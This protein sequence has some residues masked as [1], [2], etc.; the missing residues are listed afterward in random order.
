MAGAN[1]GQIAYWNG[2]IGAVWA[3]EQKKR[4]RE[5]AAITRAGLE[6]AAPHMGE[7]ALDVGCGSG[8]TT[9]LLA[10]R[11]GPKGSATGIDI[12]KPMLDVAAE[13]VKEAGSRATFIEADATDHKFAPRSFDL[14]FSQFGVMFF[15]DPVATFA[16]LHRALKPGARVAFICWRHPFENPWAH[17]PESAAKPFLPPPAP[18]DP[19][20]PGRYSFANPDRVKSVLL[21]AGFHAP[22]FEKFDASVF[23]GR[24]PQEAAASAIDSGPLMR[25]LAEADEETR[26]KVRAAVEDRLAKEMGPEGIFLTQAVWLVRARA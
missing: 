25:T 2:P 1:A 6:F 22:E 9:M 10:E 16:N 14:V 4:D 7:S 12:S 18:T 26:T 15:E 17:V 11:V 3:R 24:T 13:R 23:A 5:H 21:Q 19:N 8:T 20:A